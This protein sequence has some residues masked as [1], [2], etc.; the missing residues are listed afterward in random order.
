MSTSSKRF[1][2][3]D[4]DYEE[5]FAN[6]EARIRSWL[7]APVQA[8]APALPETEYYDPMDAG[9]EPES[10]NG[11]APGLASGS[12]DLQI[13]PEAEAVA[14]AADAGPDT[15]DV[16]GLLRGLGMSPE[17]V[18][19]RPPQLLDLDETQVQSGP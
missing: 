1:R 3:A 11:P 5:S 12:A 6:L 13:L 10:P 15:V 19:S 7:R 4:F 9:A 8:Q 2:T 17:E 16:P 18:G 14:D